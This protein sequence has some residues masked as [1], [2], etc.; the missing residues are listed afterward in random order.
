MTLHLQVGTTKYRIHPDNPREVQVQ[1][2]PEW[3]WTTYA[4]RDTAKEAR[5]L[6]EGLGRKQG[7]DE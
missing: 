6:V 2:R 3:R 1:Y 5:E 4:V 7:H